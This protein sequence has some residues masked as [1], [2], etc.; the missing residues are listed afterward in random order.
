M[1]CISLLIRGQIKEKIELCF[2]LFDRDRKNYL[3]ADEVEPFLEMLMKA[4]SISFQKDQAEFYSS[5]FIE[6]RKR[7]LLLCKDGKLNFTDLNEMTKDPFIL[8]IS[9]QYRGLIRK[10]TSAEVAATI[11]DFFMIKNN[12]NN[13]DEP[14]KKDP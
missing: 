9:H 7:A 3:S 5:R 6:F 1:C 4:I 12:C 8:E 14:Q 13:S 11:N 10:G 2:F